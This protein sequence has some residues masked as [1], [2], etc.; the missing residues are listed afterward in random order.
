MHSHRLTGDDFGTLYMLK[1][2][3]E[4]SPEEIRY[5]PLVREAVQSLLKRPRPQMRG[6]LQRIA[7][8]VG[9]LA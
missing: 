1:Q 3:M 7:E 9:V 8:H 4:A 6:D 2:I 5:F